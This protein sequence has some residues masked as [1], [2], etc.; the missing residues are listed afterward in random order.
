MAAKNPTEQIVD[1]LVPLAVD[2]PYS[3]KADEALR[4]GDIVYVPLGSREETGVV[5]PGSGAK[6]AKVKLKSV[7]A[8]A[9]LRPLPLEL[10]KLIDWI[11][12]YTLSPRGMVL[13]MALR[14]SAEL[15]AARE[16]IGVRVTGIKPERMTEARARVLSLLEN[17]LLRSKSEAAEE[18]G[19]SP[20]VI[21][22][23]VDQGA[24]ETVALPPEPVALPP[25]A[26]FAVPELNPAQAVAAK[27][28]RDAVRAKRFSVSL[29]D[30]VTGS[31][32]TEVYFEAV[33]EVLKQKRQ[34]LILLPEIALTTRFLD[35]FAER[36][37]VRPAEWHSEIAPR[38][39]ARTWEGVAKGEISVVAGA[40]SALFLPFRDL[41]LVVIDE[42]HDPA[43]KQEDGVHYHARDMAVVRGS[44]AQAAVVLTSAT[45][46]I[47][48][49]N[50][51]R[52]GRYK[53]LQLSERYSGTEVPQLEAIDLRKENPGKGRWI[54]P[55]LENAIKETVA[56][57]EQVLLFLNR[58]G[59]AP[60]TLCRSCGFRMRCVNCDSWLVEH[61]YRKK[62]ACHHCGFE[63][64]P[65]QHCPK[66]EAPDS[67]VPIGP[68][69]ERLEEEVRAA[70]PEARTLVLS[71]D[72]AGGVERLRAELEAV[73]NRDV[74]I[75]IGTQLVAKGHH[76]P[77]LALVGIVDA[78]LGLNYGDPRAAERTFQLLH[79]VVGR[80]GR[81]SVGGRGLL[82]TYQPEHP[83][84]KALLAGDRDAFYD[85]EI[86]AREEA[87]LPPFGRMVAV[88]VSAKDGP[89]A[90]AH[91][92]RL[93]AHAPISDD[94]RLLGP[95]EAP[96][97]MIRGR[98]RWRLLV[99][100]PRNFDLSYY[101][102]EWL[103]A[104]PPAKGS[105][106][107]QIDVDPQSFL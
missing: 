70:F 71:S 13:R 93:A 51:A 88:I 103:A 23:L 104:A 63:M 10:V 92:R 100:S 28:L 21:D 54:S 25:D 52:R 81:E 12:D 90:E 67:F 89:S 76:F 17:G 8:K 11:A 50:N 56:R 27:E 60:L 85:S 66:C 64:P 44:M 61:R 48:T 102:R 80:A 49:E 32:K 46:S 45:P 65:P 82:Q 38:K 83:V 33:A 36:F 94:V 95:A 14:R 97:S 15:G 68:G 57:G 39:R 84:M 105:V 73:T 1:V 43:Y 19:V 4:E 59:Y 58:R 3:Y 107:V 24:L 47:E 62:L 98:H 5:W 6:P 75:V 29:L 41:G 31:G 78:D 20:G 72:M 26:D 9:D 79:Q 37:G 7:I 106:R 35:R 99:S 86:A 91:A 42:E 55:R 40:R 69:V 2:R 101:V 34:A 96:L 30:G 77:G 22:G 87:G 16:K 74:D 18:A 53:R